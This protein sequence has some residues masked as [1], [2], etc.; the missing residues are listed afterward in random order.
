MNTTTR[1]YV[2]EERTVGDRPGV[3]R[4]VVRAFSILSTDTVVVRAYEVADWGTITRDYGSS[5]R[6]DAYGPLGQVTTKSPG[7]DLLALPIGDERTAQVTEHYRLMYGEARDVIRRAFPEL[8]PSFR[9]GR[10]GLDGEATVSLDD[11]YA[12]VA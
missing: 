6:S 8:V 2:S 5:F 12:A 9:F 4:Y 7:A 3:F 11:F 10:D 1:S